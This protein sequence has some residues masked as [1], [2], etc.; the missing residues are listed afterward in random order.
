M[1]TI[2]SIYSN[3]NL[4]HDSIVLFKTLH[5]PPTLA[6]KSIIRCYTSHGLFR[7]SLISFAKMISSG[8][9]PDH[10]VFPSVLKSCAS[11]IDLRLGESV[12]GCIIRLGVEF[13]LYTG[14]E[15]YAAMADLLGR[16][17]RLQEAY[18]FISSMHVEPTGSV[19][20]TLLAACRVHK[21]V[22]LAEKVAEKL[23][24][25]D[26]ENM[27]AYVLLS[28]IYSASKRWK[29]AAKLRTSMRVKGMKKTPA[30]SWIEVKNR[31]HAF[32]AGDKSHPFYNKIEESLQ[33][34]L[35]Q[36]EKEGYVPNT[37]DVL[38]DVDEEHK[39]YLLCS[40]SERL[41]IG[42]GIIKHQLEQLF[43]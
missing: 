18:E 17:G 26:P 42:F 19:W 43:G 41:A 8:K 16:A 1:S 25:I 21:K 35:E 32:M 4:L 6:W 11:L 38:H 3:L 15:H 29:D 10:N 24:S 7:Q 12:H 28:N 5:L 36:M 33:I 34:L 31:V 22:E 2:L 9:Y 37:N 20:L 27:G 13:D 30:C 39:R 14:L 40:H 23:L